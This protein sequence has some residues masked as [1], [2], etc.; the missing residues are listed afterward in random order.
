MILIIS[1]PCETTGEQSNARDH[2]P[3]LGAGDGGLE[4]L[5][6]ATV[7][8][9]PGEGTFNHPAAWLWLEGSDALRPSDDLDRPPA[10]VSQRPEQLW[11]T[12]DAIGE[13]VSQVRE[14]A[15]EP[16]QQWHGAVIVLN[17]GRVHQQ[18]DE[19]A[20][21]GDDVT[22]ASFDAF[23]GVKPTR[24]ATFR[25]LHTLTVDNPRGGRHVA[26]D[27]LTNELDQRG[28]DPVPR[29]IVAPKIEVSLNGRARRKLLRQGS[30]LTTRR[31]NV[32]DRVHH[33]SQFNLART[34]QTRALRHERRNNQP[35]RISQIACIAK[36]STQIF[37]SGG[38]SPSHV[39]LRRSLAT[40]T[41]S[42]RTEI[43]QYSFAARLSGR[44]RS[45]LRPARCKRRCR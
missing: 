36:A 10:Q 22:L 20:F 1:S 13:D 34:S 14:A 9:E 5:G 31:Q 35:L 33:R 32:Q 44:G 7:A 8:S 42:Q 17:V 18:R 27:H 23:C 4:V 37:R 38:F 11:S 41:E 25:R 26:S 15:P 43:T 3:S 6:E 12:I 28:V 30:P 39:G 40:T 21:R 45:L 2:D 24:A 19:R 16:S 29:T